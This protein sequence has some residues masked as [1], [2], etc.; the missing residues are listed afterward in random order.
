MQ[1]TLTPK[2]TA[3]LGNEILMVC[4][5][6]PVFVLPPPPP[7]AEVVDEGEADPAAVFEPAADPAAVFEPAADPAAVFEP[8]AETEL[9]PGDIPV[10]WNYNQNITLSTMVRG[11]K[12][13]EKMNLNGVDWESALCTSL[14]VLCQRASVNV[15]T[16]VVLSARTITHSLEGTKLRREDAGYT[17]GTI[18]PVIPHRFCAQAGEVQ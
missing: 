12:M 16:V 11:H 6:P 10:S 3:R 5:P 15:Y 2:A 18:N 13:M 8:T 9:P 14:H 4:T 7:E 1:A 17:I